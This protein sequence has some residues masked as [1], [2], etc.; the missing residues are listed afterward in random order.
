MKL[1]N[2]IIIIVALCITTSTGIA[3]QRILMNKHFV[4]DILDWEFVYSVFTMY[5]RHDIDGNYITIVH[6]P[7]SSLEYKDFINQTLSMSLISYHN[8]M[9]S[10]RASGN[11]GYIMEMATARDVV[12]FVKRTRTSIGYVDNFVYLNRGDLDEIWVIDLYRHT[13]IKL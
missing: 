7:E 4:Y 3:S 1:I 2:I 6:M 11:G 13:A 8:L 5:N 12:E 9:R 10:A